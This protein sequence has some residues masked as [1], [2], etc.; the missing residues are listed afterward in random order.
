MHGLGGGAGHHQRQVHG[1]ALVG[2]A[3][4]RQ[5]V[6]AAVEAREAHVPRQALAP[7]VELQPGCAS[8][9]RLTR[10]TQGATS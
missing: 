6:R 10:G 2:R 1:E 3:G 9:M 8:L 4:V 5:Q 7:G